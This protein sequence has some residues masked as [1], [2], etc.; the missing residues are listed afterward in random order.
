MLRAGAGAARR[1]AGGRGDEKFFVDGGVLFHGVDLDGEAA[2]GA[3]E[4]PAEGNQHVIG[5]R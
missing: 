3:G 5:L 1:R 4:R 2:A